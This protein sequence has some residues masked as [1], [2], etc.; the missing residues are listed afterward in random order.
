MEVDVPISPR[1]KQPVPMELALAQATVAEM[2][3]I[4]AGPHHATLPS[5]QNRAPFADGVDVG[6]Q[7]LAAG[8][9]NRASGAHTS[10]TMMLRE[11][12]SLMAAEP[13]EQESNDYRRAVLDE[14]ALGKATAATRSKTL[15][16][17]RKLYALDGTVPLFAA[18]R[19]LWPVDRAA[20]PAIALLGAIARDPLLRATADHVLSQAVGAPVGPAAL[21]VAVSAAFPGRFAPNTLHHIGQNTASSWHQ[22]G[23]LHGVAKKVRAVPPPPATPAVVFALY[24]GH[25]EGAVGPALFSTRWSRVLDADEPT[26][27]AM[28]EDAARSGWLEYRSSGGMVEITFRHLDDI[29][30]W[31]AA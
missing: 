28:A 15:E 4:P 19:T 26:L 27:R 24:L 16:Y 22:A 8:F 13:G 31:V 9:L 20:Q 5:M 3:A 17:L 2:T 14:N 11:L 1:A 7:A 12:R 6:A 10:K 18:L 29:T 25:L 23:Y 21:A 30:D